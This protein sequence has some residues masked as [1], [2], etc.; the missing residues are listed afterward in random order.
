MIHRRRASPMHAARASAA[1][2]YGLALAG[3]ALAFEHPLVLGTVVLVTVAAGSLANVG[4][5]LARSAVFTVPLAL[6]VA[7]VNPFVVREGV[8]VL[9]RLGEVPPVD[10]VLD[11]VLSRQADRIRR[12]TARTVERRTG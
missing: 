10:R 8:T 9:A 6:L 7:L 4:R 2:L 5:E 11:L 1:G 3:A 12:V